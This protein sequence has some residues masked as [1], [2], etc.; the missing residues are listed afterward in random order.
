MAKNRRFVRALACTSALVGAVA[1]PS[2]AEDYADVDQ[3][4]IT[5]IGQR[6][7]YSQGDISTATKTDTPLRDVAQSVTVITDDLIDDQAMR[8]TADAV[9]Y[10]TRDSIDPG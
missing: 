4:P 5:V 6:P 2:W 1:A 9:R 8:S 3:D 10:V 7:S